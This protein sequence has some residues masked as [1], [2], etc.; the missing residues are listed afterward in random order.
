M[1]SA[2]SQLT[3][4]L[5]D[6]QEAY[7]G[8]M[9]GS[10]LGKSDYAQMLEPYREALTKN[11]A[12]IQALMAG[13]QVGENMRY[14]IYAMVYARGLACAAVAECRVSFWLRL[15]VGSWRC[16]CATPTLF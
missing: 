2:S 6:F 16:V 1:A 15:V 5:K 4:A 9:G 12:D 10:A 3:S 11:V 13:S 7:T 8:L 14:K